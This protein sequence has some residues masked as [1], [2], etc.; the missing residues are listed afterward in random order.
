MATLKPHGHSDDKN[1]QRHACHAYELLRFRS[2]LVQGLIDLGTA[3]FHHA[4]NT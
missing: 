2:T 3:W 4:N 1:H